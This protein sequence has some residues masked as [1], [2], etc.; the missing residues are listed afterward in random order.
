MARIVHK[1]IDMAAKG[2]SCLRHHRVDLFAVRGIQLKGDGMTTHLFN[3]GNR[4][5][6]LGFVQ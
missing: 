6:S 5:L 2:L 1:D 4:L 3:G